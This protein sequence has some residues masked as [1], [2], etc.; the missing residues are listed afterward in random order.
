[1][2]LVYPKGA[3]NRSVIIFIQNSTSSSGAGLT[4]LVYNTSG[5]SCYY[6]RPGSASV[7][8]SLVTQTVIGAHTD[9]GFVEIDSVN[10]PGMY[11]L[12]LPDAL[13]VT[14]VDS[15]AVMLSGAANMVPVPLEIQL[16][17]WLA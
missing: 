11:R 1:M 7:Q 5:L 6:A 15:V 10:L 4:G 2:K 13:F 16:A 14:G 3:T 8:I 9:G 12:D 17:G